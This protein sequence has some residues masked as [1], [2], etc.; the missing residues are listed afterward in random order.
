MIELIKKQCS[1][2][3]SETP[4]ALMN[5]K[6]NHLCTEC[7]NK[8]SRDNYRKMFPKA[9]YEKNRTWGYGNFKKRRVHEA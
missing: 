2:C 5:R 1:C 3:K 8:K 9:T 6:V 4:L 7:A